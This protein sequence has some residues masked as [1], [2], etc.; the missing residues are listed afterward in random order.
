MRD[1]R[2]E[3]RRRKII[4]EIAGLGFCLPGSLVARTTRCGNEACRCQDDP[5]ARHGPYPSW[6]RKV[7]G[8]T[9]T[10][11]LTASQAQRYQPWF[12]NTKRLRQL[13]NELEALSVEA[14]AADRRAHD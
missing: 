14:M 10:R 8:K 6:T 9:V 13:I 1:G 2:L 11:T 4:A 12:D 5:D 7:A 3:Q